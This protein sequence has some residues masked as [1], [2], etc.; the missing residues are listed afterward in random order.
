MYASDPAWIATLGT[1]RQNRSQRPSLMKPARRKPTAYLSGG[2]QFAKGRGA[3]WRQ[4]LSTWLRDELGHAAIN[5]VTKSNRLMQRMRR[6]GARLSGKSR[7]GGDWTT[8]F[9]RVVDADSTYV[10]EHSDYVICLWNQSARRGAGTQGEL[11]LARRHRIPVYLV[12]RTPVERLPGWV[13]GCLT[14]HFGT[15]RQLQAHLMQRYTTS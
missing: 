14:R 3:D 1:Q 15:W 6:A 4:E 2:M 5:P 10:V 12:S 9:R 7:S 8:F 11:T 13:Q